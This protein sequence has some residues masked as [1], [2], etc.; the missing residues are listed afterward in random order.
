MIS[1]VVCSFHND[2]VDTALRERAMCR[3]DPW[4]SD[5]FRSTYRSRSETLAKFWRYKI[6]SV[7]TITYGVVV[8]SLHTGNEIGS[9]SLVLISRFTMLCRKVFGH[10][11][12]CSVDLGRCWANNKQ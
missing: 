4:K 11:N 12:F 9:S 10:D 1:C 7:D 2:I 5:I 3:L 6:E 8:V